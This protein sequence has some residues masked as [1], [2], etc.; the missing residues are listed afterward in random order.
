[1]PDHLV[2]IQEVNFFNI[3]LVWVHLVAATFWVGGMLFFSLVAVPLLKQDSDPPSAQRRFVNLARRFRSLVWGALFLLVMTG[4]V[5]LGNV[6]DVSVPFSSWPLVV[7]TKL[8]LVVLLVVVSLTHDRI[9]GPKVRTLK[10]KH[11]SELTT[12]ENLLLRLSPL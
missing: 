7:I 6:I 12:G 10:H 1:V 5:L 11:F 4:S 8:T 9:I 3:I 2:T